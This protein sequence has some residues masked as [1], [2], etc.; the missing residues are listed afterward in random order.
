[1]R[2]TIANAVIYAATAP[3]SNAAYV[4]FKNAQKLAKD[5]GSVMPPK[6]ILN[7]P[8]KLLKDAGYGTNYAYDYD[9]P[10][11]FSGQNYWPEALGRQTLYRPVNCGFEKELRIRLEHWT[12]L[13]KLRNDP[14]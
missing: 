10:D 6:T 11:G 13:R 12:K 14:D 2:R 8:T 7:A 5:H 3:K 1:L 4:A 9:E